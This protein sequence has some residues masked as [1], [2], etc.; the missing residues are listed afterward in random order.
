MQEWGDSRSLRLH[1]F[2][3]PSPET[4]GKNQCYL[5][6]YETPPKTNL[7]WWLRRWLMDAYCGETTMPLILPI[8]PVPVEYRLK[9]CKE[10]FDHQLCNVKCYMDFFWLDISEDDRVL[11]FAIKTRGIVRSV[12]FWIVFRW[13]ITES[14]FSLLLSLKNLSRT[15]DRNIDQMAKKKNV[16]C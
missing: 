1:I 9:N 6:I 4:C 10:N 2:V 15:F 3:L 8:L 5:Y 11:T 13:I 7:C 14:H 16:T 12:H